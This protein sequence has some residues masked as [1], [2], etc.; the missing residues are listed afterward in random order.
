[1]LQ[2]N[3]FPCSEGSEHCSSR[4]SGEGGLSQPATPRSGLHGSAPLLLR[5]RCHAP[6]PTGTDSREEVTEIGKRT[7]TAKLPKE[8]KKK[9][10][11]ILETT[12]SSS[13]GNVKLL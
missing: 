5:A 7:T 2:C 6:Q 3:K 1:M 13:V 11:T 4:D 9:E 8:K 10:K 12:A